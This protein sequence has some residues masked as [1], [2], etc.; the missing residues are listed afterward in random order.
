MYLST[1]EEEKVAN[2]ASTNNR[3]QTNPVNQSAMKDCSY[4]YVPPFNSLLKAIGMTQAEFDSSTQVRVPKELLR[5]LLQVAVAHSDFNEAGYLRENPD[6]AT[7]VG[8]GKV[9]DPRLHYVG[10]GYF[11]GRSGATPDVDEA[12]YL[13]TYTDVA[14]G[15]RSGQIASASEHFRVAGVIEGRSPSAVYRPAAEQWKKAIVPS[16]NR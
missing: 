8:S 14:D 12:W 6:V 2:R 4:M 13:R 11:E 5:L 16:S 10:F 9:D 15:V 3:I 1:R 7:A